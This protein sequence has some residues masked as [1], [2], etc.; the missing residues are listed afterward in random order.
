MLYKNLNLLYGEELE[1]IKN[2]YLRI[3]NGKITEV[4]T[5][6][7]RVGI[8]LKGSLII[9]SLINAHTHIGDSSFID[10][11]DELTIDELVKP[12][13]SLKHTLLK[14]TDENKILRGMRETVQYM[15]GSG[16]SYFVDFRE[17]GE[18]GISMLKNAC[19]G[20]KIG[21]RVLGRDVKDL[22]QIH[23]FGISGVLDMELSYLKQIRK[24]AEKNGKLF[25][26]HVAENPLSRPF[27]LYKYRRTEVEVAL[28][29]NPDIMIHLTNADLREIKLV[30]RVKGI[31]LCPSSNAILGS[32]IP[33][34]P[35]IHE[36]SLV[37]LGTDNVMINSPD[38]WRE[39]SFTYKMTRVKNG[40][41]KVS[42][43]LKMATVN[44]AKLFSLNSGI[45]QEGFSLPIIRIRKKYP[46]SLSIDPIRTVISRITPK[47]IKVL[48]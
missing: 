36:N 8:D 14:K 32:G 47:D 29:L 19:E 2:A 44:P 24:S 48:R 27:S 13:D 45:I 42:E 6:G 5:G 15:A 4:G 23:G 20:A 10:C 12:P 39:L 37:C 28:S 34:I 1:Y 26:I 21:Y 3:E 16:I 41:M 40:S 35:Q 25:A 46:I 7:K 22:S 30:R 18:K 17:G 43:I 31:V 9:P 38:M 11:Y 33:D